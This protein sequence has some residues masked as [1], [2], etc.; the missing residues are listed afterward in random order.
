MNKKKKMRL[1]LSHGCLYDQCAIV[2]WN[3][4]QKLSKQKKKI[5][6]SMTLAVKNCCGCSCHTRTL[7]LC[8]LCDSQKIRVSA[9]YLLL[10][11]QI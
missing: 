11:T 4:L 3:S 10:V 1:D 6:S 2:L 9:K 8:H 7:N 5:N